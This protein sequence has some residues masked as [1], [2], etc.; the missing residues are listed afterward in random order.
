VTRSLLTRR[1]PTWRWLRPSDASVSPRRFVP[2]LAGYVADTSGGGSGEFFLDAQGRRGLR[3]PQLRCIGWWGPAVIALTW[4]TKSVPVFHECRRLILIVESER[5]TP[6]FKCSKS[7]NTDLRRCRAKQRPNGDGDQRKTPRKG[8]LI[9]P[10]QAQR[11]AVHPPRGGAASLSPPRRSRAVT[12]QQIAAG[13]MATG[14]LEQ[15]RIQDVVE[16]H[17]E[18][19]R[20]A[21]HTMA[22]GRPLP[23]RQQHQAAATLPLWPS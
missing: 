19:R 11:C 5:L 18:L 10:R 8:S 9:L 12:S 6:R 22:H 20:R 14:G 4:Q 13:P 16:A 1:R 21:L 3:L 2:S 23:L 7:C 15:G 17:A